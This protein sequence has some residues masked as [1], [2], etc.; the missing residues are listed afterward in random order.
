[1]QVVETTAEF[2]GHRQS[3]AEVAPAMVYP[4]LGQRV[5][6]GPPGQK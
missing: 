4:S 5:A 6:L 2:A 1:V 3:E